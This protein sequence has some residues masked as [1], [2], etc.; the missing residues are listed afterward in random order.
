MPSNSTKILLL[1]TLLSEA[2]L[3][4]NVVNFVYLC[5]SAFIPRALS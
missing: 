5:D 4:L 1:I 2:Y 3:I